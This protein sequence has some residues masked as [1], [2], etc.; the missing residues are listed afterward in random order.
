MVKIVR[1]FHNKRHTYLN[2]SKMVNGWSSLSLENS[3]KIS[4][5]V[6]TPI[7]VTPLG[8]VL[9]PMSIDKAIRRFRERPNVSS[10]TPMENKEIFSIAVPS[11]EKSIYNF[12]FLANTEWQKHV[13]NKCP[14]FCAPPL[15]LT[16]LT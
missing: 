15:Y 16:K 6:T 10:I 14:V 11:R 12:K 3:D 9:Q 13:K 2:R 5:P 8:K 7:P 4:I 1:N